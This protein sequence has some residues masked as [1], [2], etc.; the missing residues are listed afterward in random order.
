MAMFGKDSAPQKAAPSRAGSSAQK[1]LSYV[2]P[3]LTFDG[4][5]IGGEDVVIDGHVMGEIDLGSS[6]RVG[7]KAHV[8]ARVHARN[9][10]VEGKLKGDISAEERVELV[11]SAQVA[12]NIRSPR[13]IVAEG[14]RFHGSVDMNAPEGAG[15]KAAEKQ[16]TEGNVHAAN[17]S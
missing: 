17:R 4:K 14:A 3:E 9:V 16:T 7:P 8:E 11:A 6:L 15:R 10:I 2:G 13:I 5:L 12:G 1:R